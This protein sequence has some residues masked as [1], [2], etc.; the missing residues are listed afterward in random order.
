MDASADWSANF[1]SASLDSMAV[2]D[3]VLRPR[4]FDPWA[5][6]LL[7]EVGVA[8]GASVLDVA[9][10][11]GSVARRAAVRVGSSGHVTG[12][13]L[14]P[15]MLAVASAKPP[16]EG[17]AE[18]TYV[19]CPADALK[20]PD[21]AFDVAVCQQGLQFFPDR[22]AALAEI[23]RALKPDGRA[24]IAVWTPIEEHPIFDAMARGLD[25]VLGQA[26]GDAY[27]GGPFGFTDPGEIAGLFADAGFTDVRVT[28]HAL[29][30][31]FE[32]GPAQLASSLAVAS[33]GPKIA[34]LDKAGRTDFVAAI[35]AALGPYLIDGTARSETATHIVVA[36]R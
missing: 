13:D 7:D 20:V 31:D 26:V 9:C 30:V 25:A 6:V 12:C 21:G 29:V 34:A 36:T 22:T 1:A 17:G 11:P 3:Q 15:A 32:G 8:P 14:S 18:I 16:V 5:E 2:Y 10:G 28:R 27:R 19:E 35:G 4:L 33:V 23:R 24:G